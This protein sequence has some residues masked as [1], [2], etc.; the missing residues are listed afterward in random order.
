VSAYH[1]RRADVKG[2]WCPRRERRSAAPLFK[3][4]ADDFKAWA[5]Q[6]HRSW[7]KDETRLSRV[8]PV[9]G[10]CRLD[11][12]TTAH[13][14]R[15]LDSLTNVAPA[16]RNRYRDLLSG[17]FK[18]AKRLGLMASN[19]VQGIPKAKEAGGRIVYLPPATKDRPAHEQEA[20]Y[21]ALSDEYRP[22]FVFSI[23]TGLRWSEQ[24]ALCWR[25]VNLLAG[26]LTVATSKNG[27]GR[28]V[29]MNAAVRSLL[30]DLSLK[31]QRTSL[32]CLCFTSPTGRLRERSSGR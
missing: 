23:N 14:E 31:R 32:T 16:T 9:F 10:D 27:D 29:P 19:P 28:T 8:L 2:G 1:A 11:T 22:A 15:F 13:V 4:Y 12:I 30:V 3:T 24:A 21:A 5:K 17:M 26:T 7:R 6:H 25:D 18:R 20:L